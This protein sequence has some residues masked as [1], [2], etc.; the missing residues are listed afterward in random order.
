MCYLCIQHATTV[1]HSLHPVALASSGF[2]KDAKCLHYT[3][4]TYFSV[5]GIFL[6]TD[7]SWFHVARIR[8]VLLYKILSITCRNAIA[9]KDPYTSHFQN[10]SAQ[11]LDRSNFSWSILTNYGTTWFT[12]V[13]HHALLE[14]DT[15]SVHYGTNYSPSALTSRSVSICRIARAAIQ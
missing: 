10:K 11:K 5:M 7:T 6:V 14:L 15:S 1:L 12:F 9:H 3:Q 4:Y 8:E 2:S 13:L